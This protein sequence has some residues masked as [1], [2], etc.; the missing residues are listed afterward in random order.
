M[1]QRRRLPLFVLPIVLV[2]HAVLPLHVFE[3]RYRRM[4]A[5]CL[6][7]D[8]CFGVLFH[9]G[10]AGPPF[11]LQEDVIGCVAEII[12]FRPLPDGRSIILCRGRERF[13]V[14]DG[15]ENADDY[16]E[17]LVEGYA[18]AADEPGDIR[19]QR[20]RVIELF[21]DAVAQVAGAQ[22]ITDVTLPTA[23]GGDVSFRIAAFLQSD[24]RWLQALLELP[25][26]HGRLGLI[27]R[28]LLD[29]P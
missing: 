2:P 12:E 10:E 25:T 5:R 29:E 19:E 18:D 16:A 15:I 6:E 26:E 9:D 21:T 13:R 3:P 27:E 1:M 14:L 11:V 20:Q 24:P 4:V 8:R 28:A 22:D 17:A 23:N 7:T